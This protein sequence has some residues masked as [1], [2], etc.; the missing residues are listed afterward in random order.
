MK[1]YLSFFIVAVMTLGL[2]FLL[3]TRPRTP[4]DA[5]AEVLELTE[6]GPEGGAEAGAADAGSKDATAN[7]ADAAPKPAGER[8]LR[9]TGLGW[10]LL[11]PGAA[12]GGV[13]AGGPLGTSPNGVG[14]NIEIAPETG[15][16]AV[17][18]R[19]ARGGADPAGADI[20][21]LPLPSFVAGYER[22]R[23]LDPRAFLVVGF[24]RG[25]EEIHAAPG[26]LAKAPPAADEV[27]IVGLVPGNATDLNAKAA[28]SESATVF[29]LFALDLLGVAPTRVRF[30]APGTTEA[31]TSLLGAV[32]KGAADDRKVVVSTTDATRL[33]PVVAIAPRAVIDANEPKLR[34]FSAAWLDGLGK[35]SADASGIARKLAAK[36][37]VTLAAGTG[38]APE[39]IA[40]LERLGQLDNA[41]LA[42]EPTWIGASAK[43]PVTLETLTQR[44]W[45][46]ARAGGLTS[47]AAPEPLPI[48]ARV[49]TAMA[50]TP[51]PKD[52]PKDG[53]A[54]APSTF[55]PLPAGGVVLL[56]YRAVAAEAD[57]AQVTAQIGFLSGVFERAAFRV[58][59]KGGDKAAKAIAQAAKE[60]FDLP[61]NRLAT[62]AAEPQGAFAQVDVV[63][64]P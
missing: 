21:I 52:A 2:L 36:E 38:G 43:G 25:R 56:S 23:A 63:A 12:L 3:L 5:P 28:G 47:T 61:S 24:S 22:I 30:V 26:A 13:D 9:V 6:A 34:A 50:I 18:A 4:H 40:L 39:A 57:A 8:P 51:K 27:K 10:E 31:K 60:K 37:G 62:V 32:I 14:P 53:D 7:V 48:D 55:A 19:L 29:G 58:S 49:I 33:V 45:Q 16:D 64:L 44:T 15:L 11:A 42:D 35:V 20:A 59:A 46:L 1:S 54:G 41:K 17:E